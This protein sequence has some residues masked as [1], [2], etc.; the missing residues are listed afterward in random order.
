MRNT[1]GI[2]PTH[3]GVNRLIRIHVSPIIGHVPVDQ[4][5]SMHIRPM[6][7]RIAAE[8]HTRTAELC[9]VML[10]AAFADL[11][12]QP[13]KGVP[14]PAHIQRTPDAWSDDQIAAYSAAGSPPHA[15]GQ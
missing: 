1:R 6:L 9:F 3:V 14:R 2:V 7:A 13:M 4:L 5:T 15:W 10:T 12:Q 8:G 11:D